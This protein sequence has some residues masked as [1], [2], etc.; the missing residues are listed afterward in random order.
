MTQ[1]RRANEDFSLRRVLPHGLIEDDSHGGG[2]VEAARGALH[3]DGEQTVRVLGQQRLRQA[4]GFPSKNQKVPLPKAFLPVGARGFGREKEKPRLGRLG[5]LQ[6]LKGIPEPHVEML[7]VIQPRP[8]QQFVLKGK[9]QRFDQVQAGPGAQAEPA[10]VAGI[11][12]NL[13]L[14][15]DDVKHGGDD[16][17]AFRK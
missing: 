8:A 2:Q 16:T 6:R 4:P 7:P 14:N 3:G 5:R 1:G 13:R 10:D 11:G 15:Q 17:G 9:A 12:R